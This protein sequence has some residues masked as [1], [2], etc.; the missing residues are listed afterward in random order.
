MD[1]RTLLTTAAAA[2]LPLPAMA[3]TTPMLFGAQTQCSQGGNP[4]V[5]GQAKAAG[6][7]IGFVR[8]EMFWKNVERSKGVLDSSEYDPYFQALRAQGYKL[9]LELFNTNPLYDGGKFPT[10][11]AAQAAFARY[12]AYLVRRYG[13][14]LVAVEVWNEPNGN[15]GYG[16][17]YKDLAPHYARLAKKVYKAVK[18]VRT[19]I[20]VLVSA[21]VK[22]QFSWQQLL[23][24][25]GLLPW[26]NGWSIHPYVDMRTTDLD[27][28][29]ARLRGI[30][31]SKPIWCTE[32]G[33]NRRNECCGTPEQYVGPMIAA[34]RRNNVRA[35]SWFLLRDHEP[36]LAT[37]GLLTVDGALTTQGALLKAAA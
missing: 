19:D 36:D 26:C 22:F 3:A 17:S 12:A 16:Y 23:V 21:S 31:G 9:L 13:D 29:F 15:W 18:A 6:L 2:A 24:D 27:A 7:P 10:S 35:C 14:G 37:Q 33:T 11:F 34:F 28:L 5:Y 1:R 20:P 30:I 25:N 32:Y 4:N 8:D